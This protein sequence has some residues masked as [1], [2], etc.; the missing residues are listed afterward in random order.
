M[1][2]QKVILR[3]LDARL[4]KGFLK[5]FSPDNG[6]VTVEDE[7]S[8]LVSVA[9]HD[10]KGIFFVKTFSGDRTYRERKSF[11]GT[12]QRGKKVFVKFR[13]GE[14]M[15]GYVEGS[16]PW[17][18]GF[19]LEPKRSGFFLRPVDGGSNNIKVFVVATAVADVTV[20]G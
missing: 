19:S 20:V 2:A 6:K 8:G 16:L 1:E 10:L 13:D 17:M 3:F 7:S 5:D 4:V 14:S 9:L 11:I 12:G 18:T 15:I